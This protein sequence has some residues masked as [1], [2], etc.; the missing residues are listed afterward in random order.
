MLKT[1]GISAYGQISRRTVSR[2]IVE[3]YYAA[4][5]QLGH[6]MKNTTGNLKLY[7]N[8]QLLIIYCQI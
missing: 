5:V 4:Q 2:V 3:R 8:E 1:A 6:E 7:S